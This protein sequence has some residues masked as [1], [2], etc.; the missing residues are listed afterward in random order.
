MGVRMEEHRYRWKLR[1][2]YA[3]VFTGP[4]LLLYGAYQLGISQ[5]SASE[6]KAVSTL[7]NEPKYKAIKTVLGEAGIKPTQIMFRHIEDIGAVAGDYF[8]ELG[9]GGH[10]LPQFEKNM[11]TVMA[12]RPELSRLYAPEF[13]QIARLLNNEHASERD[14]VRSKD[15]AEWIGASKR[16]SWFES[17]PTLTETPESNPK[18]SLREQRVRDYVESIA[19]EMVQNLCKTI[20]ADAKETSSDFKS[21]SLTST[22]REQQSIA[23]PL[24]NFFGFTEGTAGEGTFEGVLSRLKS[25]FPIGAVWFLVARHGAQVI[26][27]AFVA[28]AWIYGFATVRNWLIDQRIGTM[29]ES[30]GGKQWE[31]RRW[32]S[33]VQPFWT[34]VGAIANVALPALTFLGNYQIGIGSAVMTT[35][36]ALAGG[37]FGRRML[38]LTGVEMD[39][40][41]CASSFMLE[42]AN[43]GEQ[44][45]YACSCKHASYCSVDCQRCAWPHHSVHH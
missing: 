41:R 44:A 16:K 6:I 28:G 15:F 45:H 36:V 10:T 9:G 29:L 24:W 7:L 37:S 12:L 33:S 17:E 25:P 2:F 19:S 38:R 11:R 20:I 31:Q 32:R 5:R 43:C 23:A 4:F 30:V 27:A 8:S 1:L 21:L 42:C 39:S 40:A 14:A 3:L 26:G 34:V 18:V 35:G 22:E 13:T